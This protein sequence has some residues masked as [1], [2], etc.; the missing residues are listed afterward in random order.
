MSGARQC[1][2]G[3]L[4]PRCGFGGHLGWGRLPQR[5]IATRP[6]GETEG[7]G[8]ARTEGERESAGSLGTEEVDGPRGWIDPS[9]PGGLL[10]AIRCGVEVRRWSPLP[11]L[12]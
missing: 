4:W 7:A 11:G 5:V 6:T 1:C 2:R 3:R 12:G 10:E 9:A 8:E